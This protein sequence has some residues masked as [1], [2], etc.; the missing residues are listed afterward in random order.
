MKK[1]LILSSLFISITSLVHASNT[2][3]YDFIDQDETEA[4]QLVPKEMRKAPRV[5]STRSERQFKETIETLQR[6]M[7][8]LIK[9]AGLEIKW[10]SDWNSDVV[11]ASAG[12]LGG[13][14]RKMSLYG[15]LFRRV[16]AEAYMFVV[17][18]ELGHILAGAPYHARF[19]N[20]SAEGQAD[21]Y[22]ANV[23]L[24]LIYKDQDN[25]AFMKRQSLPIRIKKRCDSNWRSREDSAICQ[26]S[27]L[28]GESVFA[29]L[30]GLENIKVNPSQRDSRV[31]DETLNSS[32]PS[33]QC[34][35]D[36]A[37]AGA[38]CN[39]GPKSTDRIGSPSNCNVK[40]F[41]KREGA[42]PECW[43]SK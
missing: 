21:Y 32:Y 42:R 43:F 41:V 30:A 1:L 20:L 5:S 28:A 40:Q 3:D 13:K 2:L 4:C 16:S 11:N 14:K 37:M 9:A 8:P 36:T 29:F 7:E 26:R 22:A 17:C 25:V 34:R 6:T 39:K 10:I 15:G 31:A 12:D 23:C 38:Y 27:I 19:E 18:H 35:L 24:P 33:Y